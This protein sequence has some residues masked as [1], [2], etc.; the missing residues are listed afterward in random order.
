MVTMTRIGRRQLDVL[1]AAELGKASVWHHLRGRMNVA[2]IED[3]YGDDVLESLF[4]RA[5]VERGEERHT[6]YLLVLTDLG[7]RALEA[8]R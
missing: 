5:L 6:G 7:R 8:Q 1:R 4:A 2:G 3:V